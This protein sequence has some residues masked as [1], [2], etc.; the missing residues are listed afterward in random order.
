MRWTLFVLGLVGMG[1]T[2]A[3]GLRHTG[4]MPPDALAPHS[5]TQLVAPQPAPD[6]TL[7]RVDGSTM[8]LHDLRGK[9]ILLNF[10][11]SWCGPCWEEFPILLELVEQFAGDVV[12]V[13][14]SSDLEREEIASFRAHFTKQWGHVLK[15]P[16]VVMVWD[17]DLALTETQFGILR[18][19]ETIVIDQQLAMV[20]KVVG[21]QP[22]K[23]DSMRRFLAELNQ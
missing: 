12:L 13:A 10:W 4:V 23:G 16:E 1:V 17:A 3:V 9:V 5:Y 6:V 20:R 11:A 7:T 21:A 8:A 19:P 22:W 2:I 15:R 14:I 18:L